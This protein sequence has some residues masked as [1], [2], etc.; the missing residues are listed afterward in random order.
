[1]AKTVVLTASGV[2]KAGSGKLFTVNI[3]S[4]ATGAGSV[5]IYDNPSAAS[6]TQLFNG[7]GLTT[8]SFNMQSPGEGVTASTGMYCAL[9]GTTNATVVAVYE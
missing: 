7:N 9:A 5:I 8:Q 4:P 2:I 6:G 1:M 3:T